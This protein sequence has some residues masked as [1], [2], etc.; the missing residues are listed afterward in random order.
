M[1]CFPENNDRQD[2]GSDERS[3]RSRVPIQS[4]L[5]CVSGHNGYLKIAAI[6]RGSLMPELRAFRRLTIMGPS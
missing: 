5:Q 4:G 2:H 1:K 6:A 3:V